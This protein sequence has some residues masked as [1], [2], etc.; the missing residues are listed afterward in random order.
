MINEPSDTMLDR[1]RGI[2]RS[3]VVKGPP[4]Y[5]IG[6]AVRDLL[7]KR[8]AHDLDFAMPGDVRRVSRATA[9]A[10]DGAFYM[11]DEER[12]TARVIFHDAE[13]GRFV[14]DFAALRA[15]TLEGDLRS[16]DFT[17]NAIALD[18]N[19]PDELIDP[20]HGAQDLKDRVL[21]MC[22]PRSFEDDPLRVLRGVRQ[23]LAY[24][25]RILPDTWH[26]MQAAA[27]QLERV[28]MERK[29]DEIFRMAEGH[30]F[31]SALRMLDQLDV[32][33]QLFPEC[34]QLKDLKPGPP[35]RLD[36]WEHTLGWC[37]IW[38]ICLPCWWM[39]ITR[40]MLPACMWAWRLPGWD[41]FAPNW[42]NSMRRSW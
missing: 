14:L 32:L 31:A 6:G 40:M 23:A 17:V 11:L 36:A 1:I 18:M 37:S 10:L 35:H 5:L 39:C 4:V 15:G 19:Q 16:R 29:R 28:S 25:F 26:A 20:L 24:S 33:D 13:V 38:R 3:L 22:S 7:L 27:P 12:S 30:G 42:L 21:R 2:L 34:V 8:P 9:N 41:V